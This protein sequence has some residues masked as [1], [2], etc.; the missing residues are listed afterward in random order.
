MNKQLLQEVARLQT[1]MGVPNR[2]TQIITE[3]QLLTEGWRD[4]L[5]G[6]AAKLAGF[7][8]HSMKDVVKLVD[9]MPRIDFVKAKAI[10]LNDEMFKL[11]KNF[12]EALAVESKFVGGPTADWKL[13]LGDDMAAMFPRASTLLDDMFEV[14]MTPSVM[15]SINRMRAVA[16]PTAITKSAADMVDFWTVYKNRLIGSGKPFGDKATTAGMFDLPIGSPALDDI[17]DELH[18]IDD[19]PGELGPK[20]TFVDDIARGGGKGD[21]AGKGGKFADELADIKAAT[22][23]LL[24]VTN[25]AQ[26][27]TKIKKI[28]GVWYWLWRAV[29]GVT[30]G[31]AIVPR[32]LWLKWAGNADDSG[33]E[34]VAK[35]QRENA[36]DPKFWKTQWDLSGNDKNWANKYLIDGWSPYETPT[37]PTGKLLEIVKF[38]HK[39]LDTPKKFYNPNEKAIASLYGGPQGG[40]NVV[41]KELYGT[42]GQGIINS[43]L[44]ASQVAW[45]FD[46]WNLENQTLRLYMRDKMKATGG[47]IVGQIARDYWLGDDDISIVYTKVDNLKYGYPKV[48]GSGTTDKEDV[49]DTQIDI[50]TKLKE[51][52]PLFDNKKKEG[53]SIWCCNYS[54]MSYVPFSVAT[55]NYEYVQGENPTEGH[56]LYT[57]N[58]E[59]SPSVFND[60][61]DDFYPNKLPAYTKAAPGNKKCSE[62]PKGKIDDIDAQIEIYADEIENRLEENNE[63]DDNR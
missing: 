19:L 17:I 26:K 37:E 20:S 15:R 45:A 62:A 35:T 7:A 56:D 49:L 21:D 30:V 11:L 39:E 51:A 36:F 55:A 3:R 14:G 60:H 47:G 59:V 18:L 48:D 34:A 42:G 1:I 53:G 22:A 54:S 43:V 50:V 10:G 58:D 46:E 25:Q 13:T 33:L 38:M 6:G 31:T 5:L 44:K 9:G 23:D 28:G 4:D 32:N 29:L 16:N 41:P 63:E 8:G 12:D 2:T 52:S 24:K 40:E 57:A 27:S 61:F